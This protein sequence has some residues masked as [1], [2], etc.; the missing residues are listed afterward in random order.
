M[1]VVCSKPHTRPTNEHGFVLY[2]RFSFTFVSDKREKGVNRG[3]NNEI[4][5]NGN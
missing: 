3:G 5:E 2:D 4:K 1:A